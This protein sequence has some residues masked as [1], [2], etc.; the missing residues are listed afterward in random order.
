MS[1]STINC[2]R[3]KNIKVTEPAM[4]PDCGG[5]YHADIILTFEDE[6][7]ITVTCF[8]QDGYALIAD[9]YSMEKEYA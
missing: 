8:S 4:L 1:I 6:S 9:A 7:K 3:V 2:H 5:S